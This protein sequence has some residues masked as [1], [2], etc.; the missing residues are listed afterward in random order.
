MPVTVVDSEDRVRFSV[1]TGSGPVAPEQGTIVCSVA[2]L[3]ALP[4]HT[5]EV[6]DLM[7][8]VAADT[9]QEDGCLAYLVHRA[10]DAPDTVVV[11]ERWASPAALAAHHKTAHMD[12]FKKAAGSL[13]EWPPRQEMLTPCD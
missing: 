13:V 7:R 1:R 5:D 12:A 4:G 10:K 6:R 2:R 8:S 11:Y 3:K 9:R